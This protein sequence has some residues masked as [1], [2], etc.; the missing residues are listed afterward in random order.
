MELIIAF[1]ISFFLLILSAFRGI[2]PA[3]PLMISFVLFFIV[4]V[5]RGYSL[6]DVFGMARN[7]GKKAFIV[8]EIFILIGTITAIWMAAGTV[9]AI[10][11]YGIKLINPNLFI[12]STFLIS[13]C[14]S[15]LIGTSFG[16]VGTV[17][18]ALMVI[19]RSGGVSIA[20]TAGA[21]I[22]GAYFGDRCSP[23]SSS[24][25]L[26]AH[27][28]ETNIY[29]NIKNMIKT[30]IVPFF[31]SI[32]LY[33]LVSFRFPL[34]NISSSINNEIAKAFNINIIALIPAF[35]IIVFAVFKV[36]VKAS[37]FISIITAFLLSIFIQHNTILDS[38][39]FIIYG[40]NMDKASPLY[41]IIKGGGILSMLKTSL[42]ILISSA[43]SGIFEGTNMLKRFETIN[44][45]SRY[46]VYRNITITSIISALFACSQ[47]LAVIITHMLNKKVYEKNKI[48]ELNFAVDLEN[49]AIVISALIPWN[50]ALLV[51]M[52]NLGADTS[53]VPYL[54]YLYVLPLANLVFLKYGSHKG[55]RGISTK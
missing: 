20:A 46:E 45:N 44:A 25:S 17:G 15:T 23:M 52:T 35:I 55:E 53:C 22:A 29:E 9:S 14:V 8:I 51:P 36:N 13:C 48:D 32:I 19:A 6:K 2:F 11:Y 50:I 24:A 3:Y 30:S 16:T 42:V 28:T 12:L 54:F 31:I 10:V 41:S 5:R 4:A 27:L 33:T 43:L 38:I 49:T 39:R 7:G 40:Y 37:M 21:I 18:I 47:V 26:I 1:I 34:G